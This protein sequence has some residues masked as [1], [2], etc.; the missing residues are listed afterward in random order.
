MVEV[1][2]EQKE[3]KEVKYVKSPE[4]LLEVNQERQSGELKKTLGFTIIFVVAL[5]FIFDS[6]ILYVPQYSVYF[7]QTASII[8]W[9][10]MSLIGIYVALCY[11]ELISMFPTSGG[12]YELSKITFGTFIS[13]FVGWLTWLVG[14]I[15]L[16]ISIPEGLQIL[17]P[18]FTPLAY[19]FKAIIA[20]ITIYFFSQ[21]AK[22][23]KDIGTKA[24]YYFTIIIFIEFAL[25]LVPMVIDLPALTGHGDIRTHISKENYHPFFPSENSLTNIGLILGSV[26][27]VCTSLFGLS[28]VSYLAGEV[29]DPQKV[30][31]KVYKWAMII[32][33]VTSI[34]IVAVSLGVLDRSTY[35]DSENYFHDIAVKT[36]GGYSFVIPTIILIIAGFIYFSE[37]LAWLLSG[38][39]L[40]FSIAKDKLFPTHF[41]YI[42]K[43]SGTPLHAINFQA[44]ILYLFIIFT[45]LLYIFGDAWEL[46]V[47]YY[48]LSVFILLSV[49]LVCVTLLS[50]PLL[51][52]KLPTVERP[53]KVPCGTWLP[54]ILVGTFVVIT[55]LWFIHEETNLLVF[56]TALGLLLLGIPIYGL[57]VIY[58]DPDVYIK[59]KKFMV[60][61]SRFYEPLLLPIE[62][63]NQMYDYL[64]DLNNKKILQ[65]GCSSHRLTLELAE[66]V[67]PTGKVYV[68]DLVDKTIDVINAH[69]KTRNINHVHT[70][71]DEHQ[72]NRIHPHI[73][74]VDAIVSVGMLGHIQDLRKVAKEMSTL[75][76]EGG[77]ILFKEEVDFLRVIPNIGWIALPDKVIEIFA[78]EG[79]RINYFRQKKLFWTDLIVYGMKTKYD[80]PMV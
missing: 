15:G 41:A 1:I 24:I 12:T 22:H 70:F 14:N 44:R 59:L 20:M 76:P 46:D 58:F 35:I 11:A 64:G 7:S 67:S 9:I 30:L 34:V 65:Y 72:V 23:G 56:G 43:E 32:V 78:E 69:L 29:K 2:P 4:E 68:A 60:R 49:I 61:L 57:L 52:K 6:S 50:I 10:L 36:L 26:F 54:Y 66:K 16:A 39:R 31:P 79:I 3:V 5:N 77:K 33:A 53:Y 25:I 80:I 73:P 8:S 27:I 47:F 74:E 38:P 19:I 13:F 17:I 55:V 71:H 48:L 62:T 75:L 28:G 42:D 37:G 40:I 51:R 18:Y 63:K 45:Y 21:L